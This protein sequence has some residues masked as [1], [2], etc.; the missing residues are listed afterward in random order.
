MKKYKNHKL[1]KGLDNKSNNYL[2]LEPINPK[3]F[4]KVA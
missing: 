4:A 3:K 2:A 1:I